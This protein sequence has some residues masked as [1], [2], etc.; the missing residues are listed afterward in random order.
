MVFEGRCKYCS[1]SVGPHNIGGESGNTVICVDCVE[2]WQ[3]ERKGVPVTPESLAAHIRKLKGVSNG[4]EAYVIDDIPSAHG[5]LNPSSR[6][7]NME[8]NQV[9]PRSFSRV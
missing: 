4:I 2:I 5:S 3:D 7:E 6:R 9:S 1:C 8:P